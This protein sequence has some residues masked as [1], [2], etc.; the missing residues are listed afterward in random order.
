MS[1]RPFSPACRPPPLFT[2]NQVKWWALSH[3]HGPTEAALEWQGIG[4]VAVSGGSTFPE[5]WEP[6]ASTELA[7]LSEMLRGEGSDP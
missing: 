1:P 3:C 4:T 5:E 6:E 2:P 7:D